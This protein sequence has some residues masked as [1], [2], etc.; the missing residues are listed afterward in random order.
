MAQATVK[1]K[2]RATGPDLFFSAKIND[3]PFVVQRATNDW[4]EFYHEFDDGPG[5]YLLEFEMAG[6]LPQHTQLDTEGTI[7]K[8]QWIEVRDFELLGHACQSALVE[9]SHY[10]HDFNGTGDTVRQGFYGDMGCNGVVK[11]GFQ[12]P[13]P[14]WLLENT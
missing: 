12:G 14:L 13:V 3:R 5:H 7:V 11:F 10:L 1:F 2:I 6:K 4:I 8:D 9:H